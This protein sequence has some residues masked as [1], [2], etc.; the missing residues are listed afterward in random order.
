[1][2][3]DYP[4]PT[5]KFMFYVIVN[6]HSLLLVLKI[7]KIKSRSVHESKALYSKTNVR[8]L[9]LTNFKVILLIRILWFLIFAF[10]F[11]KN[12]P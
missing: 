5:S 10:I 8:N 7:Q 9:L 3:P 4:E 2:R 11:F 12:S 1:M 6:K